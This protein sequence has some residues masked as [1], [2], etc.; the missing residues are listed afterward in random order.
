MVFVITM[1]HLLGNKSHSTLRTVP[2]LVGG[3]FGV[4][5]A[6]VRRGHVHTFSISIFFDKYFFGLDLGMM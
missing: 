3:D 6:D 2:R 4:H 5:R 1:F